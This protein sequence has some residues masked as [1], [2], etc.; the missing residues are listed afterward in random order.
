MDSLL[1]G[2]TARFWLSDAGKAALKG[3][4]EKDTFQAYVHS[5]DV[6]G[7]WVLTASKQG[8]QLK[9]TGS[10]LLLKWEYFSTAQVELAREADPKA[11]GSERVH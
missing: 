1:A 3:I 5:V 6:Q 7:V 10:V 8:S 9:P 2:R 11:E 4:F